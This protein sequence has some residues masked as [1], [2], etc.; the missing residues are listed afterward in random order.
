[1]SLSEVAAKLGLV[2]TRDGVVCEDQEAALQEFKQRCLDASRQVT[3]NERVEF[4][5]F[6]LSC[7]G[8]LLCWVNPRL[9]NYCPQCGKLIY[10]NCRGDV[11]LHDANAHLHITG[12]AGPLRV[13]DLG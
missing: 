4:R 7:C 3:A 1:M 13:I 10:P 11:V 9:P 6:N 5:L 12:P 8:H 2:V